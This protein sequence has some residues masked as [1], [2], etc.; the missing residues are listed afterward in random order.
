MSD[1]MSKDGYRP[2]PM[3]RDEY[4]RLMAEI[5]DRNARVLGETI[6]AVFQEL[7]PPEQIAELPDSAVAA[8]EKRKN[9]RDGFAVN[10]KSYPP[11]SWWQTR[12]GTH[13]ES[14]VDLQGVEFAEGLAAWRYQCADAMLKERD[15]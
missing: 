12:V 5:H 8:A 10:E 1:Q 2:I 11:I 14:S 15:K 9:M 3:D 4:M 6:K 13:V 7:N